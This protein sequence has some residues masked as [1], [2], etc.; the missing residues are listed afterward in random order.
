MPT[1][2]APAATG[3]DAFAP[4]YDAFTAASDYEAWTEHVLRRARR[5]GLAGARLLDLAC[6]TGKSFAPFLRRGFQVTAC[7]VSEGMLA[8][9]AAKAPEATLVHADI[10]R[11]PKLGS[12][13]LV[14]CFDDSL[15]YLLEE[16]D[17]ASALGSIADNLSPRGLA[18]FDLN[19]LLAYRTTFARDSVSA[20][21]GLVFAWSGECAGDA[22]PGCRAAARIDVFVA[23]EAGMYE[24]VTTLHAQ[25][26]FPRERVTA[27]LGRAGLECVGVHGV[28]DDGALDAE[29]DELGHLKVLYVARLAKGGDD[30]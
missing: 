28:R 10:R 26:H 4:Y 15:N 19:T 13:D 29:P 6:G 30:Q 1:D 12:F 17:L 20:G 25:R 2:T 18:V 11:V 14:T 8:Q 3:Y 27:L 23:R 22:E 21:D 24:R 7:D 9:A 5:D 16:A